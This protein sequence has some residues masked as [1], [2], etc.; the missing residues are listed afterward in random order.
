MAERV[1]ITSE[2]ELRAWLEGKPREWA[3]AI[4]ARAALRVTPN[5]HTLLNPR[6]FKAKAKSENYVLALFRSSAVSRSSALVPDRDLR[7][8]AGAAARAAADA[9]AFAAANAGARAAARAAADAAAFAAANAGARAAADAAAFAAANAAAFAAANAGARAA[10]DAAAFAAANAGSAAKAAMWQLISAD[11]AFLAQGGSAPELVQKPLGTIAIDDFFAVEDVFEKEDVFAPTDVFRKNWHDLRTNLLALDPNW[12]LWVEWWEAARDGRAPW[13]LPRDAGNDVMVEALT[14]QQ[15]KWDRPAGK[16]NAD[17]QGLIDAARERVAADG[18][19]QDEKEALDQG[20]SPYRFEEVDGRII[21]R[22]GSPDAFDEA[23]AA[24][25]RSELAAK[26]EPLIA[27]ARQSNSADRVVAGLERL[28]ETLGAAIGDINPGL[29]LSASRTVLND[30]QV[31]SNPE[32]REKLSPDVLAAINDVADSLEDLMAAFPS[33]LRIERDRLALGLIRNKKRLDA[34]RR[35]IAEIQSAADE[36]PVVDNTARKAL[37]RF[38]AAANE[39]ESLDLL[40]AL[41]ADQVLVVRAFSAQIANSWG[42]K[43]AQGGRVVGSEVAGLGRDTWQGVRNGLPKGVEKGSKKFGEYLPE[44]GIACLGG[45]ILGPIG[46]LA[47]SIPSLGKIAN[48]LTKLLDEMVEGARLKNEKARRE[49]EAASEPAMPEKSKKRAAKK[50]AAKEPAKKRAAK[51]KS[52]KRTS[53]TRQIEKD[54][55]AATDEVQA[56]VSDPTAAGEE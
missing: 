15:E 19:Q 29:L 48:K 13:G 49:L 38:D 44:L 6:V 45:L 21:G 56:D 22:P 35:K 18:E 26:L 14:W 54:K 53:H 16:V 12:Q 42:K 11:S 50:L 1:S 43:I 3:I 40:A 34:Q 46:A 7:A 33:I 25:L 4:A 51:K 9:A 2:K 39:A 23:F 28:R 31:F 37:H 5:W 17:I 24:T 30:K 20:E 10:A 27:R 55:S 32:E 52:T 41:V 36:S 8:A 47:S